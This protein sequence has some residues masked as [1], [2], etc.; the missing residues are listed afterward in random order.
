MPNKPIVFLVFLCCLCAW[1]FPQNVPVDQEELDLFELDL[2]VDDFMDNF[3]WYHKYLPQ[4]YLGDLYGYRDTFII[5]KETNQEH[6]YNAAAKLKEPIQ[7]LNEKVIENLRNECIRINPK[8]STLSVRHSADAEVR[9][10]ARQYAGFEQALADNKFPADDSCLD[11]I[12]NL[13]SRLVTKPAY[14]PIN[15]GFYVV[16]K[17]DYLRKI[18]LNYYGNEHSWKSIY[19]ENSDNRDFLP[20]PNNPNLILPGTKIRIP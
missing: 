7:F 18:A 20:N 1:V 2:F 5:L 10:A 3:A 8:L 13:Y 17:G 16:K 12:D 6:Y 15:G 4:E 14:A 19:N 11:V 9:A